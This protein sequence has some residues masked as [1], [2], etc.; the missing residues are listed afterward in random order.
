MLQT[1]KNCAQSRVIWP[2]LDAIKHYASLIHWQLSQQQLE[3]VFAFVDGL[4][5]AIY[6]PPYGLEQNTYFNL[7]LGRCFCSSLFVFALDGTII[8]A[9]VN[10]QGS[11]HD[12]QLA[13]ELY[14]ILLKVPT[15]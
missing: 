6:Y 12:G 9:T 5:L 14:S 8:Y 10:F 4:N 1:F 2:D 7:W 11:W 3:G 15:P 13:E